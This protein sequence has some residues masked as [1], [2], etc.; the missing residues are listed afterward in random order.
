V[1]RRGGFGWARLSPLEKKP[2]LWPRLAIDGG[3]VAAAQSN[4][5]QLTSFYSALGVFLAVLK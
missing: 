5:D 4:I 3:F 1:A 2:E